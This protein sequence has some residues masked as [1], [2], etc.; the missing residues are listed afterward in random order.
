VAGEGFTALDADAQFAH[1]LTAGRAITADSLDLDE[2]AADYLGLPGLL[3]PEDMATVLAARDAKLRR[4]IAAVTD[5]VD[6]TPSTWRDTQ[7]V[8][9]D[10]H[11]MVS[12]LAARTG[13]AHGQIHAEVRQVIPGPPT[14]V[15]DYDTLVARHDHLMAQVL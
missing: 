15:A 5:E 1:V 9:K 3:S 2:D 12:V 6:F 4:H 10:I 7:E 14:A 8:R 11:R 13:K